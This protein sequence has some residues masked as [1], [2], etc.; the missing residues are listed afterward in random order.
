MGNMMNSW[1]PSFSNFSNMFQPLDFSSLWE[2]FTFTMPE[3]PAKVE[4][5]TKNEPST[6]ET[7][8]TEAPDSQDLTSGTPD[9]PTILED[10]TIKNENNPA[11]NGGGS[12]SSSSSVI[13]ASNTLRGDGIVLSIPSASITANGAGNRRILSMDEI[14]EIYKK[15]QG[16][17]FEKYKTKHAVIIELFV[18]CYGD[19]KV[20]ARDY[21][22]N[23]TEA[24]LK[25]KQQGLVTEYENNYKSV[26]SECGGDQNMLAQIR[27]S[28]GA[29]LIF[30]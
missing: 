25:E 15:K 1:M 19:V 11:R 3:P 13:P 26:H 27:H 6:P 20:K 28:Y 2:G 7:P 14:N 18:D 16:E 23:C 29:I 8:Q 17:Y 5:K 30:N 10:I 9:E 21:G 22:P 4:K 12:S 24:I